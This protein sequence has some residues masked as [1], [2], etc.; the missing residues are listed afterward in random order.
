M[1]TKVKFYVKGA[2]FSC[3]LVAS[4]KLVAQTSHCIPTTGS[5]TMGISNVTYL[6]VNNYSDYSTAY[7]DYS[8]S[9]S[10]Y[11]PLG[12]PGA[13][14]TKPDF[15]SFW[16]IFSVSTTET[17]QHRIWIDWNQDGDFNDA[18]ETI[19]T[20]RLSG[21]LYGAQITVPKVYYPGG[22]F[23]QYGTKRMRIRMA[24]SGPIML[25]ACGYT[26]DGETEDYSIIVSKPPSAPSGPCRMTLNTE[27][28]K[29]SAK[30]ATLSDKTY[31]VAFDTFDGKGQVTV[32]N[33]LGQIVFDQFVN[34]KENNVQN[35]D[36]SAMEQGMYIIK[37]D[38]G[39]ETSSHKVILK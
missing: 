7:T 24:E 30:I 6:G 39:I 12:S 2:F 36:L 32:F 26:L 22:S 34:L 3:L 31:A 17:I 19:T 8:T 23:Y 35:V 15:V 10:G 4:Q 14:G 38:N 9:L 28:I 18:N 37:T 16:V 13:P 33:S 27:E 21:D 25:S 29:G 1:K 20:S 5:T 11:V